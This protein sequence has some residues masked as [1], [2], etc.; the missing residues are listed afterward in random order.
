M[1]AEGVSTSA[2]GLRVCQRW[3]VSA[4]SLSPEAQE[5]P[6]SGMTISKFVALYSRNAHASWDKLKLFGLWHRLV[7]Y[8]TSIFKEHIFSSRLLNNLSL[9]SNKDMW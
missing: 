2:E 8:M 4:A 3:K 7:N 9:V 1:S 6:L 5:V